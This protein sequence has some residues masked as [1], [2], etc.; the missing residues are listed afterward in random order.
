MIITK[1]KT[2]KQ[3][4]KIRKIFS[5][6]SSCRTLL[7]GLTRPCEED[8]ARYDLEELDLVSYFEFPL[9]GRDQA[10]RVAEI[11]MIKNRVFTIHLSDCGEKN[12]SLY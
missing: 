3:K 8:L 11:K 6:I 1:K 4:Y 12:K 2:E 10:T 5:K 9:E 7:E